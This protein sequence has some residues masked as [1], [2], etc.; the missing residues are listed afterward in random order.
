MGPYVENESDAYN[1][2]TEG[3]K[4]RT[5]H[6]KYIQITHCYINSLTSVM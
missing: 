5:I 3:G 6:S 4:W 1:R 2:G